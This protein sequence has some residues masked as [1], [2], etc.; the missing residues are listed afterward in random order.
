MLIYL[1]PFSFEIIPNSTIYLFLKWLSTFVQSCHCTLLQTYNGK[2]DIISG[3]NY[4]RNELDVFL[5]HWMHIHC[6]LTHS[7]SS[8]YVVLL[9]LMILLTGI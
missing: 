1:C 2:E 5:C 4:W 9:L 8:T 6:H 7:L 3:I